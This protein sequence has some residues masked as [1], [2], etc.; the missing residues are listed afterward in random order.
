MNLCQVIILLEK[1][2]K[3]RNV[4]FFLDADFPRLRSLGLESP[5]GFRRSPHAEIRPVIWGR[6]LQ[7][8]QALLSSDNV[9][10]T[11]SNHLRHQPSGQKARPRSGKLPACPSAGSIGPSIRHPLTETCCLPSQGR[12]AGEH[13]VVPALTGEPRWL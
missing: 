1:K 5:L 13:E 6:L 8:D 9:L 4:C 12:A 11:H 7:K 2:K 10:P 3:K